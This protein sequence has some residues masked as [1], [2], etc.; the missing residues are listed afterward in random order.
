MFIPGAFNYS[1]GHDDTKGELMRM[2]EN[3]IQP[4]F[5]DSPMPFKRMLRRKEVEHKTGLSRATIYRLMRKDLFPQCSCIGMRAVA[6]DEQEV[7]AWLIER[8]REYKSDCS[9]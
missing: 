3:S 9:T 2:R 6:W 8:Q 1:W 7:D 4:Q 5:S